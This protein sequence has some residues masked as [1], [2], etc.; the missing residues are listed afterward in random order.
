MNPIIIDDFIPPHYQ[1]SLWWL[2]HGDEFTWKFYNHS[3]SDSS[4]YQYYHTDKP[5]KEHIQFRHV[6]VQDN[7]VVSEFNQYIDCLR[8]GFEHITGL[9]INYTNRIKANLLLKD[10][11][12]PNLQQPHI[13]GMVE[14]DGVYNGVGKKTLLYYVDDSDGDTVLYNEYFTK[15][16][17]GLVTVQQT[18]KPKKGRAII[19]DSNQIHSGTNP[20]INDTRMVIN[21]VFDA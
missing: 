20:K 2:L 5:T 19:F 1:E 17:V 16:S 14:K 15:E 4:L 6:F 13:D 8:I 12:G 7:V 11:I 21:C 9:K 10:P 3:V 18:V